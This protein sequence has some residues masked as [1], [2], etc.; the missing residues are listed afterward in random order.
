[1]LSLPE[2]P[3]YQNPLEGKASRPHW[4][5]P[6]LFDVV[7]SRSPRCSTHRPAL[8][9][10]LLMLKVNHYTS[11]FTLLIFVD[12]RKRNESFNSLFFKRHASQ[13]GVL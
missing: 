4:V 5:V 9:H 12:I 11:L 7:Q 2:P 6:Y 10:E 3:G 13:N 1:M 8:K